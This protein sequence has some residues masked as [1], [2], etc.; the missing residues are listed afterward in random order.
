M[1]TNQKYLL[2]VEKKSAW[3]SISNYEAHNI[4]ME[5]LIFVLW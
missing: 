2:N 5:T 3:M 1:V 4:F